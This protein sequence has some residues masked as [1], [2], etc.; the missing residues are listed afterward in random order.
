[1]W[2]L[3][4]ALI[5]GVTQR[6]G[7][8]IFVAVCT[9]AAAAAGRARPAGLVATPLLTLLCLAH[10]LLYARSLDHARSRF[11]STF[12]AGG[13]T[14]VLDGVVSG[15]PTARPYGLEFVFDTGLGRVWTRVTRFD[16]GYGDRLRLRA[17]AVRT[18]RSLHSLYGDGV[19]GVVRAG[20]EDVDVLERGG[21]NPVVGASW[22]VHRRARTALSRA[23]GARAGL[24]L[25]L[26]LAERGYVSRATRERFARLGISHLLALSG[27]HLGVVVGV[28]WVVIRC[29]RLRGRGGGWLL[30]LL[31]T[32][33]VFVVGPVHSL[34][35]ALVMALVAITARMLERP[36]SLPQALSR[37]LFVLLLVWPS[38]VF[39]AGFQL[40][41]AAT[42]AVLLAVAALSRAG[43]LRRAARFASLNALVAS[44]CVLVVVAPIQLHYFGRVSPV[45]PLATL[46]FLPF[47]AALLVMGGAVAATPGVPILGG[48]L[49]LALAKSV[50]WTAGAV[51]LAG[52]VT[53]DPIALPAPNLGLYYAGLAL[54][55]WGRRRPWAV[56]LGAA[57]VGASFITGRA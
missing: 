28:V 8:G 53:V 47:V 49:A 57:T 43:W 23:L 56:A 30:A 26:V 51:A 37:A 54:V 50:D 24:P 36:V 29:L 27:M 13:R 7:A 48:A 44:A 17:R 15:F 5:A 10:G 22:R 40:S 3:C 42:F 46:V 21:G 32:A 4:A 14:V 2:W 6:V 25:A 19:V 55:W 20:Y 45:S 52:R 33:Y 18:H 12:G 16:I 1:V 41:F 9:T 31:L 38:S 11:L 39:S 34:R 35:R